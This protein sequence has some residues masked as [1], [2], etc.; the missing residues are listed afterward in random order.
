MTLYLIG[1]GLNERSISTE[2]IESC[3]KADKI[4][5]ENYTVDF[6]YNK[7]EIE[8][9]IKKKIIILGRE[10]IENE[11][12]KL[13]QEAKKQNICLLIYGSP[14]IATTHLILILEAKKKKIK[15]KIIHNAS[16]FDAISETGLQMYK[17]GKTTSL[18]AWKNNYK[19]TSFVNIIKENQSISSHTLL[20][21]DIGLK[22][23]DAIKQ[24][25]ESCKEN[26]GKIIICSQLGTNN[27]KIYYNTID[28]SKKLKIKAPYCIIIPSKLHFLEQEALEELT[29]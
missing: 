17:F 22:F 27:S 19:P 15:Y 8:K 9:Q 18:P 14:L 21:V 29:K 26:L 28:K 16:I 4:Y 7:K 25:V 3:K 20:L 2:A 13:I 10:N 1:L 12:K 23:E 6:P 11:D 5:L 24:L